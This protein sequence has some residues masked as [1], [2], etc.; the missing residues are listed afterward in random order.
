M[1][2]TRN[3]GRCHSPGKLFRGTVI[4]LFNC[5]FAIPSTGGEP[6]SLHLGGSLANRRSRSG[7]WTD[8]NYCRHRSDIALRTPRA[9]C[10]SACEGCRDGR[11]GEAEPV[12]AGRW[13]PSLPPGPPLGA[14]PGS[15]TVCSSAWSAG[16]EGRRTSMISRE[17]L[18]SF[19]CGS[20]GLWLPPLHAGHWASARRPG[21]DWRKWRLPS[22]VLSSLLWVTGV[23]PSHI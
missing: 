22:L 10:H 7:E 9:D 17:L 13:A 19:V 5:S 12:L 21:R 11:V 14:S 6:P 18:Y 4:A 8:I 2:S 16:I 1:P 20:Q 15:V 23:L 3:I